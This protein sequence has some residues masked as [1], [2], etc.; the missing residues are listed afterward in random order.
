MAEGI[1]ITAPDRPSRLRHLGALAVAISLI[2][3]SAPARPEP[4]HV[5]Y[6]IDGDTFRLDTGERIRIANIDSSETQ[7]G[8]A[9]CRAEIVQGQAAARDARTLL[10]GRMVGIERVGRSYNRTVA[11]VTLN[12]RDL[13]ETLIAMGAARPRFDAAGFGA[14]F[15]FA[16]M[17][18]EGLSAGI[19]RRRT[20]K[21]RPRGFA[22][23]RGS[24]AARRLDHVTG[25]RARKRL[26]GRFQFDAVGKNCAP[27]AAEL[28][29]TRARTDGRPFE[30]DRCFG[31]CFGATMPDDNGN[32]GRIE[33][34]HT[35]KGRKTERRVIRVVHRREIPAD[36]QK[37]GVVERI[38]KAAPRI[39]RVD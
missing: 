5:A 14:V 12:G 8:Q 31:E 13:G 37:F 34:I 2:A 7:P 15:G 24:C 10:D 33:I 27:A 16:A 38:A 32:R 20:A 17:R 11:R 19:S 6:V 3:V 35:G 36:V 23:F 25:E 1:A 29:H 18:R 4:A 30:A 21:R 22:R 9:K 39:G 26:A 28:A